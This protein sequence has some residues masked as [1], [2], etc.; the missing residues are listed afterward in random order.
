[1]SS[2]SG[3]ILDPTLH[4]ASAEWDRCDI[5][6]FPFGNCTNTTQQWFDLF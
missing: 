5:C 3:S 4:S 2:Y 1:V 6:L